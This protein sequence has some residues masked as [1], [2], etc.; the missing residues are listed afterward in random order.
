LVEFGDFHSAHY[1][2]CFE[3]GICV[4]EKT[5]VERL[6]YFIEHI[7]FLVF[8]NGAYYWHTNGV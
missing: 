7:T 5:E 2:D 1:F 6:L 8:S 4:F 3:L